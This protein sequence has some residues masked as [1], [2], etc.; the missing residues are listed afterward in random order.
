MRQKL[1]LTFVVNFI[2]LLPEYLTI[3]MIRCG[4]GGPVGSCSCSVISSP[5]VRALYIVETRHRVTVNGTGYGDT[6]W[7]G[8]RRDG[9]GMDGTTAPPP[10]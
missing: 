5:A 7:T 1:D 3:F 10:P 4:F 9:I 8:D 6:G 2:Y